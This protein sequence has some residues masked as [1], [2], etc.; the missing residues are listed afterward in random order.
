MK[1]LILYYYNLDIYD[2]KFANNS[3]FFR[4]DNK[5]YMLYFCDRDINEIDDLYYL[6]N[7]IARKCKFYHK[8]IV[9]KENNLI[10]EYNQKMY[11]LLELSHIVTDKASIYDLNSDIVIPNKTLFKTINRSNW[12][13]FWKSKIDFLEYKFFHEKNINKEM[14]IIYNYCIGLGETAINYFYDIV[15]NY[16]LNTINL[17]VNHRRI[18]KNINL[19]E[20]YNPLELVIDYRS[21]DISEFLKKMLLENDYDIDFIDTYLIN[22]NLTE[23]EYNLLFCRMLFPNIYLD[24]CLNDIFKTI[25]YS[26]ILQEIEDYQLFL[27][28]VY[29]VIRKRAKLFNVTWILN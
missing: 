6:N 27:R 8:M 17:C 16:N 3:Y 1:N 22:A 7:Y 28:E 15:D 29:F 26:K 13:N 24:F 21:R 4:T 5:Q 9:N 23:L 20:L 12:A 25:N 14:K 18:K 10:I 2:V 11:I 19:I